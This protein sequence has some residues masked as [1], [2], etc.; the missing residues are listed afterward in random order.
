[1]DELEGPMRQALE[2]A[3]ESARAGSLGIGAVITDRAGNPIATGRNRLAEHDPGDDHLAGTSLA[4][5]ELNALAKLRWG[6]HG[7]E[8]LVLWTT[9]EPCLQCTGAIRMAPIDEVHVLAPD[10]LFRDMARL[11]EINDHVASRWPE[12]RF[13]PA[14]PFAVFAL[15]LQTHALA[16]WRAALPGWSTALPRITAL[17]QA[18]AASGELIAFAADAAALDLVLEALWSRLGAAVDDVVELWTG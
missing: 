7:A 14:D 11:R 8:H 4:H 12:Y 16:F 10:P 13:T 18:L 3:W 1:M 5:A 15:L 2:L 17:A 9:L 6:A